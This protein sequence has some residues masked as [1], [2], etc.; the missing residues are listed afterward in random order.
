M[1]T[2]PK[3]SWIDKAVTKTTNNFFTSTVNVGKAARG[4]VIT[5]AFLV[6]VVAA[7]L[8][9]DGPVAWA[10]WAFAGLR[11]WQFLLLPLG[12]RVVQEKNRRLDALPEYWRHKLTTG[13]PPAETWPT[14]R[15]HILAS[16]NAARDLEWEQ[17]VSRVVAIGGATTEHL[18]ALADLVAAGIQPHQLRLM[19]Q[20]LSSPL[21]QVSTAADR[22]PYQ[23]PTAD[24]IMAG[25]DLSAAPHYPGP[26]QWCDA[27]PIPEP[28]DGGPTDA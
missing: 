19:A 18:I 13:E 17:A 1:S 5:A 22:Q 8:Q 21:S 23:G 4:A 12:G 26:G 25:H 6:A 3:R 11:A 15:R 2:T 28:V 10:L 16:A 24:L 20:A 9:L 7:A 27:C 14:L